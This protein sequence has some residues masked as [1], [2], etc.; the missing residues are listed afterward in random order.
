MVKIVRL[1]SPLL[2]V[3]CLVTAKAEAWQATCSFLSPKSNFK[4]VYSLVRSVAGSSFSSPNFPNCSFSKKSTSVFANYLR[5]HFSVS[6][7][8]SLRSRAR[9]YFSELRQSTCPEKSNS[10]FCSPFSPAKFLAAASNPSSFWHE[11]SATHFQ[12]FLVFAF[13]SFNLEHIF[14]YSHS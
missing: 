13:L 3:L 14:H 7:S 4:F 1:T 12:S 11:S 5:S 8:K 6:H 10:S 2:N 9:G